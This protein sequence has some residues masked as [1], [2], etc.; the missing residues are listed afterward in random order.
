MFQEEN[1][2]IVEPNPPPFGFHGRFAGDAWKDHLPPGT[3]GAIGDGSFTQLYPGWTSKTA[4]SDGSS[5]P[6]NTVF[7]S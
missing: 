7:H 1:H 4:G 6:Q 2:R 5:S 3:I